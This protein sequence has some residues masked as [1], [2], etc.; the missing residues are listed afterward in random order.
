M[1]DWFQSREISHD[2][3]CVVH[4]SNVQ[5][6][7]ENL[8]HIWDLGYP[9]IQLNYAIG[10]HWDE[11]ATQFWV[12]GLQTLSQVLRNRWKQGKSHTLVNLKETRRNVRSN[13]HLTVDWDGAVYGSNG[14]LY[15]EKERERFRLGHLDEAKSYTRYMAEG[16]T[17]ADLFAG[18]TWK[19]S[20]ENNQ[21]I[22]SILNQFS[23]SLA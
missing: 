15:L 16:L 5:Q 17:D 21:R 1:V 11:Q 12:E 3:I 2:V 10:A 19:G 8:C 9:R 20:L 6:K 18:W 4:P 14:F 22:G 13:L 7:V 23:D